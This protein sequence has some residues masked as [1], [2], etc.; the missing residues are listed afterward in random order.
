MTDTP[1]PPYDK[2]KEGHIQ[3]DP[4]SRGSNLENE[5]G[6]GREI[7]EEE[8]AGMDSA[9]TA[10]SSPLGV[11]ESTTP[12]GEETGAGSE[13]GRHDAGTT[14]QAER[15]AGTSTGRDSSTIDPQEPLDSDSPTMPA[16]DQGG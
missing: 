13:A 11:G 14:G 10:A 16:G 9:D 3:D 7:T 8:L 12:R 4:I 1:L 5:S 6:P 2:G 15:P